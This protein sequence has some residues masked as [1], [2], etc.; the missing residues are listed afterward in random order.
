MKC[1]TYVR[2]PS[3]SGLSVY[4][5]IGTGKRTSTSCE[6]NETTP[7][8]A[9]RSGTPADWARVTVLVR[10]EH[11]S[12][13]LGKEAFKLSKPAPGPGSMSP[14]CAPTEQVSPVHSARTHAVTQSDSGRAQGARV[15][16]VAYEAR[17]HEAH[18][19]AISTIIAENTAEAPQQGYIRSAQS[20][21]LYAPAET[22]RGRP[23][24]PQSMVHAAGLRGYMKGA[25]GLA[26]NRNV[27]G[28]SRE[29]RPFSA[30]QA[31]A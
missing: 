9:L 27:H 11:E 24:L 22:I 15:S 7:L 19:A 16:R 31:M 12:G 21:A 2:V 3:R 5:H 18:W 30:T 20:W 28:L 8:E 17:P 6:T 25:A 29:A 10:N 13:H 14:C 26:R 4:A 23:C 1:S